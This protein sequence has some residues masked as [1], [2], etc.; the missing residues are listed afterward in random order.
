MTNASSTEQ[1]LI[2]RV[3]FAARPVQ[4]PFPPPRRVKTPV[5]LPSWRGQ[6]ITLV[7]EPSP[8]HDASS[9]ITF[10]QLRARGSRLFNHIFGIPITHPETQ[11]RAWRPPTSGHATAKFAQL[12]AHPFHR[13]EFAEYTSTETNWVGPR[14]LQEP[15]RPLINDVTDLRQHSK[16][17]AH[18]RTLSPSQRALQA[19]SGNAVLV[20]PLWAQRR[21]DASNAFR[22]ASFPKERLRQPPQSPGSVAFQ[23]FPSDPASTDALI[24]QFPI[25]P[26]NDSRE[27]R[28]RVLS[29]IQ[30]PDNAHERNFPGFGSE[31]RSSSLSHMGDTS[32]RTTRFDRI[33]SYSRS[34]I[35]HG[36]IRQDELER[37]SEARS[38][39]YNEVVHDSGVVTGQACAAEDRQRAFSSQSNELEGLTA[40]G[41]SRIDIAGDTRQWSALTGNSRYFSA[42]ST[43]LGTRVISKTNDLD[44]EQ[45]RRAVTNEA[46]RFTAQNNIPPNDPVHVIANASTGDKNGF[47]MAPVTITQAA[48]EYCLHCQA[49]FLRRHLYGLDGASP[50]LTLTSSA[51]IDPLQPAIPN[52]PSLTSMHPTP[53]GE[54]IN[55]TVFLAH[56]GKHLTWRTRMNKTKCWRC[57]LESRRTASSAALY[58]RYWSCKEWAGRVRERMRWTCLCRY[59]GY[60]D[61]SD[62]DDARGQE[63]EERARLGRMGAALT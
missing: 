17:Q 19:A 11:T 26:T 5:G 51:T 15:L 9:R 18:S 20:S 41:M 54:S 63:V 23:E 56:R 34:G 21:T 3:S 38:T 61:D 57:E 55:H 43:A 2:R 62:E 33:S 48:R 59:Q 10:R 42:S 28:Q 6:A 47:P 29:L 25:P 4:P 22:S 1:P 8:P 45:E 30:T 37:E 50:P 31:Q 32:S 60:E 44:R 39:R 40:S 35:P 27:G 16:Q 52:H 49:L 46:L 58:R 36:P 53:D 12:N 13:E 24:A 14:L 7:R